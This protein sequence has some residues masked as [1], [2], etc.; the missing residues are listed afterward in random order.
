MYWDD[1]SAFV[2]QKERCMSS[3][4]MLL[5]GN[6]AF[7]D[8]DSTHA[9]VVGIQVL[10]SLFEIPKAVEIDLFEGAMIAK[11]ME[12]FHGLHLFTIVGFVGDV[13][14]LL[15]TKCACASDDVSDV[16]FLSDVV[17]KQVAFWDLLLHILL[18]STFQL[19]IIW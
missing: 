11:N 8:F 15:E 13:N 1:A 2:S 19:L 14:D 18:I 3:K 9:N 4:R 6:T 12:L 10:F 7:S 16:V 17:Q 5:N